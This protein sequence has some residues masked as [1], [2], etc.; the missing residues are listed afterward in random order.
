MKNILEFGETYVVRCYYPGSRKPVVTRIAFE[1]RGG[2]AT[3]NVD[4]KMTAARQSG[5]QGGARRVEV[6]EAGL[7]RISVLDRKTGRYI[8]S[9]ERAA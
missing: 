1:G 7:V 8:D 5:F 4:C 9:R 2:Y 3:S 6:H